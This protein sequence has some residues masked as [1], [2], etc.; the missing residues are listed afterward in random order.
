M[1]VACIKCNQQL[2]V[3]AE[4]AGRVCACPHCGNVMQMP[5]ATRVYPIAQQAPAPQP[6]ARTRRAARRQPARRSKTASNPIHTVSGWIA[7]GWSGF[8]L[9][10]VIY[11]MASASRSAAGLTNEYE[12][13]GAALG[14]G[15]G[16]GLW[17]F[18]WAA[19]ALPA[20]LV[21]VMTKR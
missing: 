14:I 8:C 7:L 3:D 13:A 19:V 9:I 20:A 17:C 11:G 15:L 5:G 6:D 18:V 16:L 2:V 12:Q 21:W 1:N 4:T 10:G